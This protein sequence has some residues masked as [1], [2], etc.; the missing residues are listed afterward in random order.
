M[1]RGVA[2]LAQGEAIP[3]SPCSMLHSNADKHTVVVDR[4]V[5][6]LGLGEA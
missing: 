6:T 1:D 5:A 2:T 4:G 3:H